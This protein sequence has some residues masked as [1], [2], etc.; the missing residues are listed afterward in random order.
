MMMAQSALAAAS[1]S[2]EELYG[3]MIAQAES[4]VKE[5]EE[6]GLE[7]SQALKERQEAL[8]QLQKEASQNRKEV[9]CT[10]QKVESRP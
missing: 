9:G 1:G 2:N 3:K 5:A 6:M 4:A 10:L 7:A 8:N